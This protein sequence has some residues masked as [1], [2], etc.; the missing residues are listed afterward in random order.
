MLGTLV[1][2][3]LLVGVF[4]LVHERRR[5]RERRIERAR[6]MLGRLDGIG[7][8]SADKLRDLYQRELDRLGR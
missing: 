2:F 3:A 5:R 1:H 7:G 8:P 6:V 4:E